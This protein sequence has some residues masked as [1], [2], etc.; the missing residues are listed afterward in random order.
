MKICAECNQPITK[1]GMR[2]YCS[3]NCYLKHRLAKQTERRKELAK[4]LSYCSEE[5]YQERW[6]KHVN[7][8]YTPQTAA[9]I[10]LYYSQGDSLK[11]I[12][13]A[14]ERTPENVLPA[15]EGIIKPEERNVKVKWKGINS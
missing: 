15:L 7:R 5:T 13:L 4:Q 1:T 2:K 6:Q 12:C 11:K 3:Y 10:R 8:S 9:L 14:L